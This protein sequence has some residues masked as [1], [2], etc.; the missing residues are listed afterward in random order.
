MARTPSPRTSRRGRQGR[1]RDYAAEYRRRVAGTAKGSPERQRKRGHAPPPGKT[2]AGARREREL[3]RGAG[4]TYQRRRTRE[5]ADAQA[6]KNKRPQGEARAFFD[7]ILRD[8]GYDAI[9]RIKASLATLK[10]NRAKR[11]RRRGKLVT[12]DFGAVDRARNMMDALAA[13]YGAGDDD[14]DMF[15]YH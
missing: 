4:T 1:K 8:R 6:K 14:W 13:E 9:K 3:E 15:F 11:V 12:I 2:E 7:R 10:A 5:L